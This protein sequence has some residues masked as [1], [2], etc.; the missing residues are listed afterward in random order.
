MVVL[1]DEKVEEEG[2]EVLG[3][4]IH[5]SGHERVRL[6]P[7]GTGWK[8]LWENNISAVAAAFLQVS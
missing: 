1:T 4:T 3:N 2:E 6:A 8:K 7:G 5:F